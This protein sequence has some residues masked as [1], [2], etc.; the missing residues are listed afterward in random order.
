MEALFF[1]KPPKQNSTFPPDNHHEQKLNQIKKH[2]TGWS[3]SVQYTQ[4]G[5]MIAY[6]L[7]S[8]IKTFQYHTKMSN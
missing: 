6:K 1:Q 8:L 2:M 4:C 7:V 5:E 3:E